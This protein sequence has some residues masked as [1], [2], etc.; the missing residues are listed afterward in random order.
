MMAKIICL[1]FLFLNIDKSFSNENIDENI[2]LNK[3]HY[4]KSLDS[5]KHKESDNEFK[6]KLNPVFQWDN[7]ILGNKLINDEYNILKDMFFKDLDK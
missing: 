5:L 4:F 1:I 7:I 6:V 3:I 2:Y